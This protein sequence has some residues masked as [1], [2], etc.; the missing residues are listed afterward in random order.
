MFMDCKAEYWM[1][2]EI[3]PCEELTQSQSNFHW[4]LVGLDGSPVGAPG[5][6]RPCPP[7]RG[8]AG[9]G[10]G[11]GRGSHPLAAPTH[12][13]PLSPS[14]QP[15]NGPGPPAS[16]PETGPGGSTCQAAVIPVRQGCPALEST[17][18]GLQVGPTRELSAHTVPGSFQSIQ[19][20][21]SGTFHSP[22]STSFKIHPPSPLP[23]SW[24]EA[25]H[26]LS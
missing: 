17:G 12:S 5:R 13:M 15:A 9:G 14:G 3:F 24:R 25:D 26:S 7:A 18:L 23:R 19:G 22:V 20:L 16:P 4:F 11:A 2:Y 21:P 10:P 1:R 8:R 6:R